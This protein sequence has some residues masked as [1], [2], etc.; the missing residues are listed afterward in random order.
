MC[1]RD[2]VFLEGLT[3]MTEYEVYVK[4]FCGTNGSAW[5]GPVL[6]TTD[7]ELGVSDINK[8]QFKLYPN[9]VNDVVNVSYKSA[10]DS[11]SIYSITGQLVYDNAIH[12]SS[13]QINVSHLSSGL[14]ILEAQVEGSKVR[15]KIIVE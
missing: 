13:A 1:I 9:P 8:D 7:E 11:I 14:Y 15:F 5:A 6:F 3:P 4:A 10:I 12:T 2:R